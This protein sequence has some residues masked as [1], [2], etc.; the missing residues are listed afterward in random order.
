MSSKYIDELRQKIKH[1]DALYYL[2]DAPKITD[3]EYD[4]LRRELETLEADDLFGAKTSQAVGALGQTGFKKIKHLSPML[5]LGNA[6]ERTDVEDFLDGIRRFLSLEETQNIDV[7]CELKIDGLSVNL[8]YENGQLISA[9]TRGD[10]MVGEDVTANILTIKTI[11][12]NLPKPVPEKIEIRGEVYFTKKDF[13]KLNAAQEAIN[14]PVF[15]NPRNAAAGSLRQL[16]SSITAQRAIRFFA[17]G[18]GFYEGILFESQTEF[19][20]QLKA[21]GFDVP[22]TGYAKSASEMMD[23]YN[24]I[25]AERADLTFDIDG[26]V[27]KVNRLDWQ[28]RLG[29]VGRAPRF[30]I[31]HKFPAEQA[32]THIEDILIQVGRTGAL[33]PVAALAAVNVGGVMVT[34]ATLHNEDEILR[35]D[36]RVGDTVWVQRAGDVIP[37]IVQV[38][39]SKR[40][41]DSKAFIYPTHCPVCGA[42]AVREEGEAVRRC[43]GGLSCEAQVLEKLRHFVSKNAFDIDGLGEKQLELFHTKNWVND[44]ADIFLL[45]THGEELKT[46]EGFGEKS[47]Q[48]LVQAIES[49]RQIPLVRFIYALGIRQV[50]EETAKLLA[51]NYKSWHH[52]RSQMLEAEI[53]G[54]VAHEN[55]RN[56]DQI[57]PKMVRDLIQFFADP[58]YQKVMDRLLEQVTPEDYVELG[59]DKP[60]DGKTIVFTGSLTKMSRAEAKA[61]AE[62]LGAKVAGSVSPKTDILVAGD[63]AG[64]KLKRAK[65]LGIVT[66]SE[67]EW[68]AQIQ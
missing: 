57:G 43:T 66:W 13:F 21:W 15:A 45:P 3:A 61:M 5:S 31:A 36:A 68:L 59:G 27:Y 46:M 1:H 14:K 4:A 12:Q 18:F 65:E 35:K 62:R 54:S 48:N 52:L 53:I 11:P 40:P 55:L 67:D 17:Y 33:T 64:S 25:M 50:G 63:D 6:F 47:V 24:Q 56:I 26:I 38:D 39:L 29:F 51:K 37:Q 22:K 60:F 28:N 34:R 7:S 23:F 16:D 32:I 58:V 30:A 9:T 41:S 20:A 10:G 8:Y 42:E 2:K 19:L 44:F 49:K